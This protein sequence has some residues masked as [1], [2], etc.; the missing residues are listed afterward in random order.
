VFGAGLNTSFMIAWPPV[1]VFLGWSEP[2]TIIFIFLTRRSQIFNAAL[3]FSAPVSAPRLP[4]IV[5]KIKVGAEPGHVF[6][7]SQHPEVVRIAMSGDQIFRPF[8]ST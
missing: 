2:T 3:A 1:L 5:P 6:H 8:R 7:L 4:L